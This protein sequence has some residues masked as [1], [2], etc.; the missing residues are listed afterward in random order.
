[1]TAWSWSRLTGFETCP[2]KMHAMQVTKEFIE[3]END[4]TRYGKEVHRALELRVRDST[5]LPFHLTHLEPSIAKIA[6]TKGVKL[7]EQK[8]ALDAN[9]NPCDWMGKNVW[10]RSILDLAILD[11]DRAV[12]IDYKT[13]KPDADFGQLLLA[14]AMFMAYRPNVTQIGLAYWFTRHASI[15]KHKLYRKELPKVW[16]ELMPRVNRYQHAFNVSEFPARQNGLCKK[17][18]AVRSC[19]YYG[20]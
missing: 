13:G 1:M 2:K 7:T 17:Y 11:G 6:S 8:M 16:A 4:S 18:C 14:G 12:I 9:F 19:V 3:P 10:V 5:P 15:P 20:K